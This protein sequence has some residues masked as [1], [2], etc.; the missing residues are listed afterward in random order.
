MHVR[1]PPCLLRM[2]GGWVKAKEF[3]ASLYSLL[4]PTS[5]VDTVT[6]HSIACHVTLS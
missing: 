5:P 4:L 1:L 6:A 2:C 3:F